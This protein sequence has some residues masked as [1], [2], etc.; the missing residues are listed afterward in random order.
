MRHKLVYKRSVSSAWAIH[1]NMSIR[2]HTHTRMAR[3]LLCISAFGWIVCETLTLPSSSSLSTA[4][5]TATL[6]WQLYSICCYASV[7]HEKRISNGRMR[8]CLIKYIHITL[9]HV[10]TVPHAYQLSSTLALSHSHVHT[11]IT[12]MSIYFMKRSTSALH[13]YTKYIRRVDTYMCAGTSI[14]CFVSW[15]L[16]LTHTH[17][18]THTHWVFSM[19]EHTTAH[20]HTHDKSNNWIKNST[21]ITINLRRMHE[22]SVHRT[23]FLCVLLSL[24]HRRL[25]S[26]YGVS[27]L[28]C[29][30]FFFFTSAINSSHRMWPMNAINL[31]DFYD[32]SLCMH[33]QTHRRLL[34]IRIA[35]WFE[36]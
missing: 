32:F 18:Q 14:Y 23:R 30:S 25:L 24:S 4:T 31:F 33:F 35:F 15:L 3:W 20:T 11:F 29:Y 10:N 1:M 16:T 27:V 17:R 13:R 5:A 12:K 9:P 8:V 34:H 22:S 6:A 36:R 19:H 26:T 21:W 28:F 7:C 2:T